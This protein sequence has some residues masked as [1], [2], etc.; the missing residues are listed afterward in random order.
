MLVSWNPF[1]YPLHLFTTTK[2]NY[3]W[4]F[5]SQFL[6][7]QKERSSSKD[8]IIQ[9]E[10]WRQWATEQ[11]LG[12]KSCSHYYRHLT[13]FRAE[14]NNGNKNFS[15]PTQMLQQPLVGVRASTW[16]RLDY[17]AQMFH[18]WQDSFGWVAWCRG[19]YLT[20]HNT[21]RREPSMLPARFKTAILASEQPQT[22]ALGHA[23]TGI[24]NKNIT[25]FFSH[26]ISP[27]CWLLSPY[28]L[29]CCVCL[30][31]VHNTTPVS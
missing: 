19:L 6:W 16:S 31:A 7:K 18:T 8:M 15:P 27:Y 5:K 13:A 25:A 24:D 30:A 22:H 29:K 20:T 21:H 11:R 2:L 23:A 12:I 10:L 28:M 26:H 4:Y 1:S 3:T 17:H 14:D 9:Y